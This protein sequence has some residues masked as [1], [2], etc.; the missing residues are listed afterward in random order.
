MVPFMEIVKRF[1][2][3]V[4][5]L[6]LVSL[7]IVGLNSERALA[8]LQE[9]LSYWGVLMGLFGYGLLAALKLIRFSW[10]KN[11]ISGYALGVLLPVIVAVVVSVDRVGELIN[12]SIGFALVPSLINSSIYPLARY[13]IWGPKSLSEKP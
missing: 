3:L 8:T 12:W 13:S 9:R 5:V 7:I 1:G 2:A 10:W 11:V 4:V 6:I